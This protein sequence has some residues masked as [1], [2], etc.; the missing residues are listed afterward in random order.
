MNPDSPGVA[1]RPQGIAVACCRPHR[2]RAR[3]GVM[4]EHDRN[5]ASRASIEVPPDVVSWGYRP[6]IITAITVFPG[7][8]AGLPA[9]PGFRGARRVAPVLGFSHRSDGG[10]HPVATGRVVSRTAAG[11]RA[12]AV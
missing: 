12:A 5:A 2:A 1:A 7:V 10:V 4:S 11:R 9:L 3:A 6:G 8:L